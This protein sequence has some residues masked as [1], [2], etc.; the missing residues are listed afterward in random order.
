[1]TGFDLHRYVAK[2][3]AVSV[4]VNLLVS[5]VP[6][7][8]L[9]DFT[10]SG[11]FRP[12]REVAMDLTPGFFMAALMSALV[13]LLLT[14]WKQARGRLG[15]SPP[16]PRLRPDRA[17]VIAFGLA[18]MSTIVVLALIHVIVAPLAASGLGSGAILALRR[19]QAAFAAATVTPGAILLL[20]GTSWTSL[21]SW[22]S[23][24]IRGAQRR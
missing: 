2:E 20:F 9:P 4:V 3:T 17:A 15:I 6:S 7:L 8:L 1:M 22:G 13:P 12:V 11:A 19:G 10:A 5:T 23:V 14:C 21:A 24:S 18:I 16:M